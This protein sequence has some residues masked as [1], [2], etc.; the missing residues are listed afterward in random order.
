MIPN[1]KAIIVDAND[2]VLEYR[3]RKLV[4]R[5]DRH[6]IVAVWLT[7]SRGE[8]LLAQR[9]K[10]VHIQPGLWG[11]AAAGT[12]THTQTYEQAAYHEL[13][14]EIGIDNVELVEAGKF[15]V[16]RNRGERR[17]CMVYVGKTDRTIA[18]LQLQREEVGAVRWCSRQDLVQ[19]MKL[20]QDNYVVTMDLV[21]K[22]VDNFGTAQ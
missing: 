14:E 16:N 15:R 17:M 3:D 12:V 1:E 5:Y 7:N 10:T 18:S 20:H 19:D 9:A 6:R 22:V 21:L 11:P 13:A 8:V 2:R 4:G